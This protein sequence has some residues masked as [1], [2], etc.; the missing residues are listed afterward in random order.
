MRLSPVPIFYHHEPPVAIDMAALQSRIT[1]RSQICVDCCKL[2]AAQILGFLQL[3]TSSVATH[4]ASDRKARVLSST[5]VPDGIPQEELDSKTPEVKHIR[6][7]AWKKKDVDEIKTNG[8]VDNTLEAALWA[9]WNTSSF[10]EGMLL[11]LPLGSDVDTVCGVYGQLAGALYGFQSIPTRWLADLQERD[12]LSEVFDTLV[13]KATA[14]G[15][16]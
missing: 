7:G 2:A 11:L 14:K 15:R 4:E 5:F 16:I 3:A 10:E 12:K 9:L 6:S 8:A 1:H 13:E